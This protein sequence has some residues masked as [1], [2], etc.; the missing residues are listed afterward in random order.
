MS[1]WNSTTAAPSFYMTLPFYTRRPEFLRTDMPPLAPESLT[2][3]DGVTATIRRMFGTQ[4]SQVAAFLESYY[5]GDDW[6]IGGVGGW[7]GAYLRDPDVVALGLFQGDALIATIFSV[8]I[9]TAAMSHGGLVRQMRVIEGLCVAPQYRSH[10]IAG[11]MIKHADS[12]TSYKFGVS[13]HLW[14]KE[15]DVA[16]YFNTA[17]T[18]DL[19]GYTETGNAAR[20]DTSVSVMDWVTFERLWISNSVNWVIEGSPPCIVIQQPANI[21]RSLQVFNGYGAVVVV[22]NTGRYSSKPSGERKQIYEIV[23][24]GRYADGRLSPAEDTFD[25][26][27]LVDGVAAALPFSG[28]L[29]GTISPTGGGLKAGWR[30]W[31]VGRSGAHALYIYN[32]MPPAFGAC[33]IHM[34]REEI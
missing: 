22:S 26:K 20:K 25:F 6:R 21:R 10:G 31:V 3:G 16:P 30:D 24:S 18:T 8:P 28:V 5:C 34:I 11:F 29:F 17:L 7:I 2:L 4:A 33:R 27:Q 15:I 14:A 12:F 1:F 23:W 9:G 32:Y 19:Y 13:A